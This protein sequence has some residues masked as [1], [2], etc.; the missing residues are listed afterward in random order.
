MESTSRSLDPVLATLSLEDIAVLDDIIAKAPDATAFTT[1]FKAYSEVLKQRGLDP[2]EDVVYYK[3]LLK[4]GVIKG[5]DWGTKWKIVKNQLP[6]GS[7]PSIRSSSPQKASMSISSLALDPD[8][9]FLSNK[10]SDDTTITNVSSSKILLSTPGFKP[11]NHHRMPHKATSDSEFST[12][13]KDSIRHTSSRP[14]GPSR[15]N[16]LSSPILKTPTKPLPNSPKK[17]Y[18]V[19]DKEAWHKIEEARFLRDADHFRTQ[20]LL[21]TCFQTWRRGLEWIRIT[22]HQIDE[23]RANI[24]LHIYFRRWSNRSLSYKG[25][26]KEVEEIVRKRILHSAL[27][28]WYKVLDK[29]RVRKLDEELNF[30]LRDFQKRSQQRIYHNAWMKWRQ[31][32]LAERF[33]S[34]Q[35]SLRTFRQWLSVLRNLTHLELMADQFEEGQDQKLVRRLWDLWYRRTSLKDMEIYMAKRSSFRLIRQVLECWS[36]R[37]IRLICS[38]AGAQVCKDRISWEPSQAVISAVE[39]SRIK[40]TGALTMWQHRLQ[41]KR[42]ALGLR[43]NL[44]QIIILANINLEQALIFNQRVSVRFMKTALACWER[45]IQIL[46]GQE[47][48]A[49]ERYRCTL[50]YNAL[51]AWRLRLRGHLSLYRTAKI[52]RRYFLERSVWD[53]WRAGFE[54][55]KRKKKLRIIELE[56]LKKSFSKWRITY[57]RCKQEKILLEAHERQAE[58]YI[59]TRHMEFWTKKTISIKLREMDTIERYNKQILCDV[60]TKWKEAH[61]HQLE[62]LSLVRSYLDVKRE[63]T[64][65][66]TFA[67]WLTTTRRTKARRIR[68]VEREEEMRLDILTM[69][70]ERWRD[71]FCENALREASI[72]GIRLYATNLKLKMWMKWREALPRAIQASKA[73]EV[74]NRKLFR[75]IF[76]TWKEAYRTKIALKAV[77]RARHLRLPTAGYRAS[78]G[79]ERDP[80]VI[81]PSIRRPLRSQPSITPPERIPASIVL[82]SNRYKDKQPL[83]NVSPSRPLPASNLANQVAEPNPSDERNRSAATATKDNTQASEDNVR[84]LLWTKLRSA[85]VARHLK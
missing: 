27:R 67:T 18:P 20:S 69:A 11:P 40:Q 64:L 10:L 62:N 81:K 53:K 13:S 14:F 45:K 57:R 43:W 34:H 72:P 39:E 3:R 80:P 26:A 76:N 31:L 21:M 35:L 48:L 47:A 77:T 63:E 51:L 8:D 38:K 4:L 1:I 79:D 85:Q 82:L 37:A 15:L 12:F 84:A 23:A 52:A 28:L 78:L 54:T 56:F 66:R 25:R 7:G 44:I 50:G 29:R 6:T 41:A 36:Q 83:T 75:N 24:Q 60:F 74:H 65:R 61:S 5:A 59:L 58:K 17:V 46:R 73:E 22:H 71:R 68:L 42:V 32:H 30:K 70:W 2:G 9:V 55:V 16:H 19:N 49:K 33:Y